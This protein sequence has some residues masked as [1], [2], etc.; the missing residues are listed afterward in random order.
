M[1][2][3]TQTDLSNITI[4]TLKKHIHTC[5]CI[6]VYTYTCMYIYICMYVCEHVYPALLGGSLK[7]SVLASERERVGEPGP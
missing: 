2:I 4:H 6:Y 3:H 7:E 1:Y 5:I